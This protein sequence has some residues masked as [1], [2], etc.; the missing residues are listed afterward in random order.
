MK[1]ILVTGSDTGVGKTH[2]VAA[3]ARILCWYGGRVRIVKVVETGCAL[4]ESEQE[5]DA[6]R[7]REMAG[8]GAL[9]STLERYA[10]PLAPA[11][12]AEAE[13]KSI[14]LARLVAGV[15]A[16]PKCDWLILEGAGGIASPLDH[17]GHDWADFAREVAV[18]CTV[19]VVPDRLG[20][21]GQAR[22]A[23][24]RATQAGLRAGLWLNATA[25]VESSVADSN[26]RVLG[27]LGLPLWAEQRLEALLP[28]QPEALMELLTVWSESPGPSESVEPAASAGGMSVLSTANPGQREPGP[29]GRRTRESLAA[30]EAE[31]LT[32]RLR[33]S[34]VKAG[35]LNLA[36][37][38]YLELARD[39]FVVA[40]AAAALKQHGVS[41]S[42]SPLITGW[43]EAHERLVYALGSWHG[44]P[45]GLVWTSGYAAN[46]GVLGTLPA[47]GD[48]VLADKLIHHSMIAGIQR[49]GA[50]LRR[51]DHLNLDQLEEM[52]A[53]SKPGAGAV[54]VVSESV[55]SMDGDFPDLARLA[56]LKRRFGFCWIL[57]EAHAVGWYGPKGAGLA[58]AAGVE[59]EVDVLVGTLG[60]ALG[61]GGAYS[62]FHDENIRE[63]LVNEAPEFVY[64]TALPPATA[65]AATAAV[66]RAIELSAENQ[67]WQERS[68]H[69]RA[70]LR[71]E[72][73]EAASGNSPIVPIRLDDPEAA[74]NLAARLREQG[75]LVA[76]VRPPTVPKGTS[77]LRFSLKRT[78]GEPEMDRVV[79][80]LAECRV[81]R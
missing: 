72:G 27:T 70:R 48:L 4:H 79:R 51:Y 40:A 75:I 3:L 8:V 30:R 5:G 45:R 25:P 35:Q 17:E 53:E 15:A 73:W 43:T 61:G 41:A 52:L 58:K 44:F 29:I 11:A 56:G 24:L 64:S 80:A 71:A 65:A 18:D 63:F 76:A 12:A 68:T 14:S 55:F 1:K 19:V 20:A 10:A 7:A 32:R 46:A 78:F 59:R 54:F 57:D 21:I 38:D 26:R 66:S 16:L 2:V 36:N 37:N 62:L 23:Y 31:N 13:G 28:D 74:L 67:R 50:R 39:P 81:D 9:A 22:M 6:E 60:K 77:R 49:S 42:A 47:K 33:V 34:A 69:F